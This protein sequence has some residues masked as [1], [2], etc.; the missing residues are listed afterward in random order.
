MSCRT[1]GMSEPGVRDGRV[2]SE[3]TGTGVEE[4]EVPADFATA[5]AVGHVEDGVFAARLSPDWTVAEKPHGGHLMAVLTRAAIARLRAGAGDPEPAPLAVSAQ[6]LRPP[7]VGPAWLRTDVRKRGRTASVVAVT[8]EQEGRACVEGTVTAGRLPDDEPAWESLPELP[9][10]P[11]ESAVRMDSVSSGGIF[12]IGSACEVRLDPSTAGFLR[13]STDSPLRLRLW[14]RPIG[15]HPDPLFALVAGDINTPVT[16]NLGRYGWAPTVQLTALL[17]SRPAPGW[18]RVQVD[19]RSVYGTWFDSDA[20]VL[21][22][23]G[24]L[25]CQA[26]Q[27]ALSPNTTK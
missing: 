12:K 18:L 17:R 10:E 24:R 1:L 26:R 27:L 15:Q 8:L 23:A 9:A 6:F 16:F 11:P 7:A 20:T 25:V 19:C 3:R 22:S 5:T 14:T 13:G 2:V 4:A 21:D